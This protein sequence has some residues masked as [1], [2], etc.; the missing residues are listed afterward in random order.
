MYH[1]TKSCV[2]LPE[3]VTDTFSTKVGIKQGDNLSPM[4]YN[5]FIDDVSDIF[6]PV[7]NS[8]VSLDTATFNCLIYA[9][10]LLVLSST[11][12]G[13]PNALNNLHNYSV[14]WAL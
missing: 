1:N 5:I 4:L 11:A 7:N 10:V 8:A 14:K 12:T 13:L 9:D 3:G 6:C 2:K